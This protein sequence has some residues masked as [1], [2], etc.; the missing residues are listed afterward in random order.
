MNQKFKSLL[1][2]LLLITIH[3]SYS[4]KTFITE[5]QLEYDVLHWHYDRYNNAENDEW[6]KLEKDGKTTFE[7]S[8]TYNEG[9]YVAEY[10]EK[11][12]ILREN[13]VSNI[14]D[15]PSQIISTLD[16]RLVKYKLEEYAVDS[17]FENKQIVSQTH[18]VK[19][20]SK[21]GGEIILW[22]DKEFNVIPQ[23]KIKELANN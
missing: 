22:F 19:S 23:K 3:Y 9:S 16:Y 5:N 13:K 4:Q 8:F 1:G 2:T 20:R 10:D 6:Y 15:I 7:V 17:F 11:G 12:A 14:K 18:R 21:T